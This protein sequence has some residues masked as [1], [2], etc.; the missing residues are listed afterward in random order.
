MPAALH[1]PVQIGE[2]ALHFALKHSHPV[3]AQTEAGRTSPDVL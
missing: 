3:A 1:R 2:T